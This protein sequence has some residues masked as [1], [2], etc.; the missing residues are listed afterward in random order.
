MKRF[1][2]LFALSSLAA[3]SGQPRAVVPHEQP[4]A[5]RVNAAYVV[6][7]GRHTG[8][9]LAA[10]KIE[11]A[12]PDLN[13]PARPAAFYEFGWGDAGY[14]QAAETGVGLAL[15]ALFWP[16]EA[17]MH[18]VPVPTTPDRY[19]TGEVVEACLT[20]SQLDALVDF[21][22]GSFRE[23]ADEG[24]IPS[25]PGRY[26]DSRFYEARG[27][28]HLFN[29]SNHWTAKGLQSAGFD[30]SSRFKLTS[31]PV[32]RYIRQAASPCAASG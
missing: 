3:C 8:I 22:A 2:L 25:A 11:A 13:A 27:R 14:Y 26:R 15:H 10:A 4:H 16:S 32:M 29:T 24:L 12:L 21:V 9:A 20:Q 6:D 28:Y 23:S 19:F 1:A 31:T 5:T 30:L 7:H 18:V 17:T